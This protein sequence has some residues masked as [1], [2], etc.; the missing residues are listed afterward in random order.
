[1]VSS[2]TTNKNLEKPGNGDY[3]DTWNVPVNSDMDVI[4]AAFGGVT[5]LNATGGS[6]VLTDTQYQKMA[7]NITGAISAA[8]VYTIPSGVGGSWIV[9]NA[10]TDASGGPWSVTIAS[11]GGGSSVVCTRN[12]AINI[13]SDGTNIRDVSENVSQLGTVTSVDVSGG[14]TGLTTS[15][16][17]ITTSG[18]ITIAGTLGIANGG[19]GITSFGT[20]VQTALGQNVTGTGGIVLASNPTVTLAN[21]TGLPLSTGVTGTLPVTNGGTGQTTYTDGQLLIGNSSGNTLTKSTLTAGT[22]VAITNGN[23]SITV[24]LTST[25]TVGELRS[26]G[27][28]TAYYSDERLKTR[29]GPIE[30]PLEMVSSLSGFYYEAN[31]TAQALGYEKVREVGVSAQEVAAILPEVVAE[32][33]IDPQYLTVRYERLVP[34]LIEAIKELKAKVE[35]LE[36]K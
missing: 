36:A 27:N 35:T 33:P 16:G 8:V 28:V 3:V 18:T 20:G 4:D 25:V 11:G 34:L 29:L 19:T 22:N 6:A 23:G 26:T 24:G 14:T 32:A 1:M 10:T 9:R 13:Y 12:K 21:A 2:Y 31:E 30:S 7:L 5:S 17:P 15:G